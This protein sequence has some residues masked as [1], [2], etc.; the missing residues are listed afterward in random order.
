MGEEGDWGNG[1]FA[2]V[3]VVD[4]NGVVCS[5]GGVAETLAACSEDWPERSM[6]GW[7]AADA[8]GISIAILMIAAQPA[9]MVLRRPCGPVV[10]FIGSSLYSSDELTDVNNSPFKSVSHLIT[11]N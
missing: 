6:A 3:F 5:D 8:L 10:F 2:C 4:G 1:E 9:M 7:S 11:F